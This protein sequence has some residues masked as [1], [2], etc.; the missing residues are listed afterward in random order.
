MHSDWLKL[1]A[2]LEPSNPITMLY[3]TLPRVV[4]LRKKFFV[5]LASDVFMEL[6]DWIGFIF[7]RNVPANIPNFSICQHSRPSSTIF[8]ASTSVKTKERNSNKG[9]K[10]G[11]VAVVHLWEIPTSTLVAFIGVTNAHG[12][13][14]QPTTVG[15][16]V[17]SDNTFHS[18]QFVN[19]I[20]LSS[21]DFTEKTNIKEKSYLKMTTVRM[22]WVGP[23]TWS[24]LKHLSFCIR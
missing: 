4:I 11:N 14:P 10:I 19:N 13:S 22:T 21:V 9:L 20:D 7:C 3:F 6:V 12:P 5:R 1:I 2:W 8:G 23:Q 24:L 18:N 16:A 15:S 17:A